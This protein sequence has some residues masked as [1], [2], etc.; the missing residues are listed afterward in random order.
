MKKQLLQIYNGSASEPSKL[1]VVKADGLLVMIS[2]LITDHAIVS[3]VAEGEWDASSEILCLDAKT[4]VLST[5]TIVDVALGLADGTVTVCRFSTVQRR[6][7]SSQQLCQNQLLSS[8]LLCA[9]GAVCFAATSGECSILFYE[10]G[11]KSVSV[12]IELSHHSANNITCFATVKQQQLRNNSGESLKDGVVD[13]VRAYCSAEAANALAARQRDVLLVGCGDGTVYWVLLPDPVLVRQVAAMPDAGPDEQRLSVRG[14]LLGRIGTAVDRLVVAPSGGTGDCRAGLWAL[15]SDGACTFWGL[16]PR[17]P[18]IHCRIL[19]STLYLRSSGIPNQINP[20]LGLFTPCL[21][22]CYH[23]LGVRSSLIKTSCQYKLPPD[24][25][26]QSVQ[27][28]GADTVLYLSAETGGLCTCYPDSGSMTTNDASDK[29]AADE[30]DRSLRCVS[31]TPVTAPYI[32]DFTVLWY[33]APDSMNEGAV[34]ML[35][36][37]PLLRGSIIL[38]TSSGFKVCSFTHTEQRAD[39]LVTALQRACGGDPGSRHPRS[40]IPVVD[41]LANKCGTA[42]AAHSAEQSGVVVNDDAMVEALGTEL[43]GTLQAHVALAS[44]LQYIDGELL[45]LMALLDVLGDDRDGLQVHSTDALSSGSKNVES[46]D[47]I[48]LSQGAASA[49]DG[50]QPLRNKTG[51]LTAMYRLRCEPTACNA[52]AAH[53]TC[54]LL[55][56]VLTS[57][58]TAVVKALQDRTVLFSLAPTTSSDPL[59]VVT[60]TTSAVLRFTPASADPMEQQHQEPPKQPQ[61]CKL[62]FLVTSLTQLCDYRL[63]LQVYAGGGDPPT[64]CNVT[65]TEAVLCLVDHIIPQAVIEGVVQLSPEYAAAQRLQRV[66]Q[67]LNSGC[68]EAGKAYRN[69]RP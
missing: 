55:D 15:Q 65:H 28:L 30:R 31:I 45:R 67:D 23:L 26:V 66:L 68:P 63:S 20:E 1:A 24:A 12:D 8:V 36:S 39:S 29:I 4:V 34:P 25:N 2:V 10:W 57:H 6:F 54:I 38:E 43:A 7:V 60:A 48:S 37:T 69:D 19:L 49:L 40:L 46:I 52:G 27:L 61:E 5:D 47:A 14:C 33:G 51:A 3:L 59:H 56:M 58:T 22:S 11:A 21:L 35:R 13:F 41:V 9:E 16:T 17:L 62:T 32:H 50:S 18:G 64:P 42:T 53:D 44:E